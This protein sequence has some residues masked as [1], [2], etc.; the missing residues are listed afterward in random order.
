MDRL[1]TAG[2]VILGLNALLS[3]FAFQNPDW[4][5]RLLLRIRDLNAGQYYRLITSAFIH[6]DWS[7]LF[8]N[9][10]SLYIF[11]GAVERDLGLIGFVIVYIVSLLGGNLLSWLL[12]RNDLEYRA[13]GAS[14]AVSGI[15]YAAI[16]IYPDMELAFIFLPFYF[17]AWIY[18][19]GFIAYSFY[20][21]SRNNDNIGHEA[22][23]GGAISGLLICLALDPSIIQK[24]TLTIVYILVPALVI[25]V[26]F[27]FKP[28]LFSSAFAKE[29][30]ALTIDDK[31]RAS[32]KE[33]EIEINRILEKVKQEGEASLTTSE[34]DFLAEQ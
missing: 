28:M 30:A 4:F 33:K 21:M 10:F 26:V 14:G 6:V 5:E 19:I 3:Y 8:F 32:K 15:I 27:L 2:L 9:M 31:Y 12:H 24:S 34:R 20:G 18:G 29:D 16:I 1:E 25:L 22:H 23:L 13:V 7:H 11:A 17:P